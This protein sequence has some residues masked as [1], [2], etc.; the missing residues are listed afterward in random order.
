MIDVFAVYAGMHGDGITRLGEAG[1]M[2]DRAQRRG[3]GAGTGV[4]AG[5]GD[6]ELGGRQ[7]A[8]GQRGCGEH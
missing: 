6:V 4:T 7:S 3:L 5:D 1:G 8:Q 2:L